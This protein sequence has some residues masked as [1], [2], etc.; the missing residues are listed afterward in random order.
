M[1]LRC[2]GWRAA[3]KHLCPPRP[4]VAVPYRRERALPSG[5][6]PDLRNPS[7]ETTFHHDRSR[8]GNDGENH[9]SQI[10]DDER[11]EA[12]GSR[13]P[14][15]RR[16]RASRIPREARPVS[17]AASRRPTRTGSRTI[18]TGGPGSASR[19]LRHEQGRADRRIRHHR[20]RRAGGW[21]F[22]PAHCQVGTARTHRPATTRWRQA[23]VGLL[24]D[25]SS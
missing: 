13:A 14:A 18:S 5:K 2:R 16:R 20:W 15:R 17:A 22:R 6:R 7:P 11:Y 25:R 24:R 9:G 4:R 10:K 23:V 3:A 19:T 12:R 21:S 8:G 1:R